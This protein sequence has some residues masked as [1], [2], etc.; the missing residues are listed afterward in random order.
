MRQFAEF[1][2]WERQQA[3]EERTPEWNLAAI[4]ALY[5]ILPESTRTE[6]RDTERRGIRRMHELLSKLRLR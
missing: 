3:R 5:E 4:G 1:N 6:E 2:R